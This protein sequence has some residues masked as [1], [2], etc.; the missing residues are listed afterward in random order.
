[1]EI[2]SLAASAAM[3]QRTHT[4]GAVATEMTKLSHANAEAIA[5]L[6]EAAA[7]AGK[8]ASALVADSAGI[9]DIRV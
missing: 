3:A 5:A 2:A 1:M 4:L 9:V 6:L 7:E 8:Q